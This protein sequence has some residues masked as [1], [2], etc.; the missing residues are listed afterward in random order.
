MVCF[1]SGGCA[2]HTPWK[3][4]SRPILEGRGRCPLIHW[5]WVV[6]PSPGRQITK[7]NGIRSAYTSWTKNSGVEFW[8]AGLDFGE[9]VRPDLVRLLHSSPVPHVLIVGILFIFVDLSSN[10]LIANSTFV[11]AGFLAVSGVEAK[12]AGQP[13]RTKPFLGTPGKKNLRVSTPQNK[14]KQ[15]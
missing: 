1:Y 8:D 6:C 2:P 10:C 11:S 9:Q 15:I 7:I 5:N 13:Q 14:N 4:F 12:P 3:G